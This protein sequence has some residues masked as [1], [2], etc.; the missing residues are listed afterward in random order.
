MILMVLTIFLLFA[1]EHYQ[2]KGSVREWIAGRNIVLRWA[3][4]YVA[5]FS[6][7]IFGIYGMGYNAADFAYGRF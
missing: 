5:I 6:V 2:Q 1:V 7:L 4:Y 3:I